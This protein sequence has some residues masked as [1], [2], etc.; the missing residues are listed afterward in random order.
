MPPLLKDR[1]NRKR[2]TSR[3]YKKPMPKKKKND[4]PFSTIVRAPSGIGDQVFVKL[5]YSDVVSLEALAGAFAQINYR[6][7]SA[8]DPEAAVGGNQPLGYDQWETFFMRYQVIGCAINLQCI[9][10]A[11][12]SPP[13]H[14][15]VAIV[16]TDTTVTLN[17][18]EQAVEFP[19]AR[20]KIQSAFSNRPTFLKAYLSTARKL[21]YAKG[22]SQEPS[23]SALTTTNPSEQWFWNICLQ[24]LDNA[25]D[26]KI[27]CRVKLTYYIRF[28]D[29]RDLQ[30][31]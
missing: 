21:G 11:S 14:A 24:A 12:L 22:I 9:M 8:F 30:R 27:Q 3:R 2:Y 26:V 15:T 29:R 5:H 13:S 10:N 28:F 16:P 7:N 31:S 6:A 20:S 19:Y 23:L 25:S 18:M 4:K 17:S 1:N